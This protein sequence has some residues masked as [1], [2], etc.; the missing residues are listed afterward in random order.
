MAAYGLLPL[1]SIQQTPFFDN[2]KMLMSSRH[3]SRRAASFVLK[4]QVYRSISH[5]KSSS[6]AAVV[7]LVDTL[8]SKS[9]VQ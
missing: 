8:D 7:E 2:I 9:D 4:Y 1:I 3:T 5:E 6:Y